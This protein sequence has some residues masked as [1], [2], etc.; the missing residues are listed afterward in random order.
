MTR[1]PTIA[2]ENFLSLFWTSLF[3]DMQNAI[4]REAYIYRSFHENIFNRTIAFQNLEVRWQAYVF[5]F[6]LQYTIQSVVAGLQWKFR[7]Q[8]DGWYNNFSKYKLQ[9]RW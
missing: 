1:A 5:S 8:P 6:I 7:Y 3:D 9:N 4:Y 2:I